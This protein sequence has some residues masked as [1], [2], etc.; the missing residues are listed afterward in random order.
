MP[1]AL[2]ILV[3]LP[4]VLRLSLTSRRGAPRSR[5]K[6]SRC[7]TTRLT[8]CLTRQTSCLTRQAYTYHVEVSQQGKLFRYAPL[9][10]C[11]VAFPS[12]HRK[13]NESIKS[14]I[15]NVA[16]CICPNLSGR[17]IKSCPFSK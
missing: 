13:P 1:S 4:A 9:V 8:S 6:A 5:S 3:L 7:P 11:S 14:A 10:V 2:F 17:H 16:G 15:M 12:Y